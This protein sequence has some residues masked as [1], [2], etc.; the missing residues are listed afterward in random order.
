MASPLAT[1]T[2]AVDWLIQLVSLRNLTFPVARLKVPLCLGKPPAGPQSPRDLCWLDT[3]APISVVPFHVHHQRLSWQS[4][5]GIKTT[6]AGQPCDLGRIDIWLQTEQ[7]PYR[8]G[9]FALLA[10]FPRSDPPGDLV[11]VLLGLEFFLTHQA[12]FMLLPPPQRSV[13]RL[14]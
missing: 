9:P 5:P 14:A 8:R 13:I 2:S 6:W 11:P 12:E 10:K 3:G 7:P 4:I 1:A